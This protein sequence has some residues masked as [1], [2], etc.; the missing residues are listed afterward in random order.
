MAVTA[1]RRRA[2]RRLLQKDEVRSQAQLVAALEAQGF[3]VTQATISRDL[4]AMGVS[5]DGTR[6]VLNHRSVDHRYLARALAAYA[7]SFASSGN[8]VVLKTPPG[9]AQ[10]VAAAIDG[11]DLDGV[12]G[13]VA[14]DDTVL[15]I[16]VDATGGGALQRRLEEIGEGS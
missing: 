11:S 3:L 1:A 15:V 2:L 9:A 12:L 8:L 16:A 10:M 7:E 6:Y 4:A 14:G 13:T 5:K